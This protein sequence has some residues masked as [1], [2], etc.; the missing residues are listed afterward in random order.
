MKKY[1]IFL[2][3]VLF[4]VACSS[5]S[6]SSESD[7]KEG[8]E[9][10]EATNDSESSSTDKT[11]INFMVD[12]GWEENLIKVVEA[13]EE[14]NPNIDVVLEAYPF[15]S[16]FEN[17]EIKMGSE[18]DEYDI[19]AVDGP[20]VANYSV[21][22][23]LEPLGEYL[24]ENITDEWISSS[25]DAAT[26]EG[27]IMAAP[28]NSSSQIMYYNKELFEKYDVDMPSSNPDE[29]WTWKQTM[30]A[31][32]QL[33]VD[34]DGDGTSDIFG[35]SFHQVNRI[36]QLLP[37]V[38][39]QDG[40]QQVIGEN[41]ELDGYFN[42]PEMIKA[43]QFYYDMHNELEVSP[44]VQASTSFERFNTGDI[45]MF[46]GGPWYTNR[47]TDIE[48]G[49]APHPY[50]EEGEPV[51]PTGSWHMG[52]PKF[53]QEKEAAADLIEFLS[54]GEGAQMWYEANAD[55]P[56]AISVLENI[57]ANEEN[58]DTVIELAAYEVQN[59]SVPRPVTPG[60]AELQ[61]IFDEVFTDIKNGQNPEEA[62]NGG[63]ARLEPL[64]QKYK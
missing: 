41:M 1:V 31:A 46:I 45:A 13:Y 18:S 33:T 36:Y 21:K 27:E 50:F 12:A 35:F 48:W 32:Q 61:R 28:L 2:A 51:T 22:G 54:T 4:L 42:S 8:S 19:I 6:G 60:F 29:R 10:P 55:I 14:Q 39:S 7:T 3:V 30:D 17:I 58:K 59:T 40:S 38:Q 5:E 44:D 47:I 52:I 57:E 34:E 49:F 16:L 63:T 62:I 37:L 20:M 24:S 9:T 43:G 56:S 11:Q 15:D 53:S 26:Y 25:A 23:Y 64:L